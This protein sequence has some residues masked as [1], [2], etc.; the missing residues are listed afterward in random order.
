[1]YPENLVFA[2]WINLT[3][4]ENL[5]EAAALALPPTVGLTF[6]DQVNLYPSPIDRASW[7]LYGDE[8]AEF[9]WRNPRP[10]ELTASPYSTTDTR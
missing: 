5:T 1:M 6:K 4:S 9:H 3:A 2:F 8:I 7:G 10:W